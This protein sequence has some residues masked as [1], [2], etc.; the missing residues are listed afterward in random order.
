MYSKSERHRPTVFKQ[1]LI[2]KKRLKDDLRLNF[3]W[4]IKY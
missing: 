2:V 1:N 3:F 4:P